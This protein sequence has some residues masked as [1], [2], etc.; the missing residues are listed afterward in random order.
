MPQH[1]DV[2]RGRF[3]EILDP[4]RPIVWGDEEQPKPKYFTIPRDEAEPKVKRGRYFNIPQPTAPPAR[5]GRY[6][7]VP[8]E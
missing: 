2:W 5:R 8:T 4:D 6:F 7:V 1:G 3:R